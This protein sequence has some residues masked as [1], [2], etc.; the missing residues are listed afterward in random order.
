[1]RCHPLSANPI[2]LS[3]DVVRLFP[4]ETGTSVG[5]TLVKLT[6]D[7]LFSSWLAD[8]RSKAKR[9]SERDGEKGRA[10]IMIRKKHGEKPENSANHC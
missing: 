9:T 3:C 6:I 7:R 2:H 1:V 5:S 10:D 8:M 4:E